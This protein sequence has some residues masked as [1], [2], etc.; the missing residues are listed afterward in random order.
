[1]QFTEIRKKFNINYFYISPEITL[2]RYFHNV[3]SQE[4]RISRRSFLKRKID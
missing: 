3:N 4:C 2:F 1:M